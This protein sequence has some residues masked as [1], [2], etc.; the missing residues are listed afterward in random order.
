MYVVYLKA[1]T[2]SNNQKW[3][4]V[5]RIC[6]H[7]SLTFDLSHVI[8]Y[9]SHWKPHSPSN[10]GHRIRYGT[11]YWLIKVPIFCLKFRAT[12]LRN[13]SAATRVKYFSPLIGN[14]VVRGKADRELFPYILVFFYSSS[15]LLY[16]LLSDS[17]C[18]QQ[19]MMRCCDQ[20]SVQIFLNWRSTPRN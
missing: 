19:S 20:R 9:F 13:H 2:H 3:A 12:H 7:Y 6:W 1:H 14:T 11:S 10:T 17:K 4:Y 8:F 16:S 5:L 15:W 18:P